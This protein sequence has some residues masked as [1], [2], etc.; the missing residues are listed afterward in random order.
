[1]SK[2]GCPIPVASDD[3]RDALELG[4]DQDRFVPARRGI[5]QH[6]VSVGN[7]QYL[8]IRSSGRIPC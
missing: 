1:M 4:A 6:P 5:H 8:A 2:D 3:D 7:D